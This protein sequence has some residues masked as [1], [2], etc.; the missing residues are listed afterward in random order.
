M[1]R[2]VTSEQFLLRRTAAEQQRVAQ[3]M[4]GLVAAV[5]QFV[6]VVD[7]ACLSAKTELETALRRT[8]DLQRIGAEERE[9]SMAALDHGG[10]DVMI[11]ERDRLLAERRRRL[12]DSAPRQA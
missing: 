11:A 4:R 8:G 6:E 3:S 12:E 9:R 5:G 7:Q 2:L 10:L 1:S